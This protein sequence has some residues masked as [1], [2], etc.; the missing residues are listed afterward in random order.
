MS[1]RVTGRLP[2][3]VGQLSAGWIGLGIVAVALVIAGIYAYS[4][5]LIDGEVVT[6]LGNTGSGGGAT[7]GLYV[8]FLIYFIGVSF[9]GISISAIVRLFNVQQLRPLARMAEVLTVIAIFL[10]ALVIIIDL[11]QPLRGVVNL[12]LYARPESPLFFTFTLVISG[13]LFASLLYLY[14]TSRKDAAICAKQPGRL[15]WFHRLWA[16]G[17]RDTPGERRRHL[18]ASWWLALAILPLL[19]IAHSVLGFVFGSQAGQPGW[20]STLQAPAFVMLA[21]VS[22]IGLLIVIAAIVRKTL[23]L[24]EQISPNA[25]RWL[26][27]LLWIMTLTY[28]YFT[29]VEVLTATYAAPQGE[30]SVYSA[31][32]SGEYAWLFWLTVGI[33][34]VSFLLLFSQFITGRH[35]IAWT[36]VAGVLVSMAAIGKRYIVVVPSQTHGAVLPYLDGSYSPTWVEYLVILGL[37]GLGV[38][39]YMGFIKVF[40]IMEVPE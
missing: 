9:A 29:L 22:G 6:G 16:A 24:Q 14:L 15:Q 3:G 37:V 12:F 23:R 17:Y 27:N 40:P 31:I 38:L 39:L 33:M 19:V 26:G 34:A 13:Y 2:Y 25:F 28:L 11:G 32:V 5:Q 1:A 35:S 18:R 21:G 36:V 10:G 4:R 8:M 30:A 7:W 20:Y